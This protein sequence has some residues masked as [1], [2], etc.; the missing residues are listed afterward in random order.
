M[1]IASEFGQILANINYGPHCSL[2]FATHR[3]LLALHASGRELNKARNRQGDPHAMS[4]VE[5]VVLR[6]SNAK[7]QCHRVTKLSRTLDDFKKTTRYSN[8]T[9]ELNESGYGP[10]CRSRL[11][12]MCHG[13]NSART[14][15]DFCHCRYESVEQSSGS[16][17]ILSKC[18][19]KQFI[20]R[21]HR[22]PS[23]RR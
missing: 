15:P 8:I 2:R 13:T 3:A 21:Q 7:R 19:R 10:R 22:E 14:A 16:N 5:N 17:L 9:N 11:Y 18:N 20:K 6:R 23:Q 12:S 1:P 4:A